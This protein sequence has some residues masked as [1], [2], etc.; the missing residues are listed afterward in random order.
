MPTEGG[1]DRDDDPFLADNVGNATPITIPINR[2]AGL[3]GLGRAAVLR[4][5]RN[6]VSSAGD[7]RA[8]GDVHGSTMR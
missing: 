1:R 8:S 7:V 5:T 4:R 2:K 6:G 3:F